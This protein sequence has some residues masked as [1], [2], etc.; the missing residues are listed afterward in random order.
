LSVAFPFCTVSWH[1]EWRQLASRNKR[2][3]TVSPGYG[4]EEMRRII[5]VVIYRNIG[6]RLSPDLSFAQVFDKAPGRL[7]IGAFDLEFQPVPGFKENTIWANLDIE[8][9]DPVGFQGFSPGMEMD[10]FPGGGCISV[11]SAL[12]PAQPS[13]G[14]EFL[15]TP[16]IHIIEGDKPHDIRIRRGP[17]KVED[18]G[19]ADFG[20]LHHGGC[21]E[22]D[23]AAVIG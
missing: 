19:A 7:I 10:R 23:T 11:Q 2:P 1:P 16:G 12:G 15:L 3:D 21:E 17:E 6:C 18:H 8:F 13:P 20:A 5:R 4:Q 22:F 14:Q 9:I